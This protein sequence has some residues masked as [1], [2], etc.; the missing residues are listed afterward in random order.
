MLSSCF[1]LFDDGNFGIFSTEGD[2]QGLW[3]SIGGYLV[4]FI[5]SF[6]SRFPRRPIALHFLLENLIH[7][8]YKPPK[9]MK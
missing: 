9:C 4:N 7:V 5:F 3:F 8:L 1:C 2:L 6:S